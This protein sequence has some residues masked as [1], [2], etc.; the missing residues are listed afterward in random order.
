MSDIYSAHV[1]SFYQQ[2]PVGNW[3]ELGIGL[4]QEGYKEPKVMNSNR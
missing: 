1:T 3:S 4:K 2:A